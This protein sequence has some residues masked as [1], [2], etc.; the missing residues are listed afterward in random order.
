MDVSDADDVRTV[1]FDRPDVMNAFTPETAV[2]LATVLDEANPSDHDAVVLTGEGTAFSAGG[3]IQSMAERDWTPR[4]AYERVEETFGRLAET[5]LS[6]PV[7]I[8]AK[9][10]GDA[11]GA[12]LAVVAAAD[13]AYATEEV[14]L[15]AAFAKVGLVPDTAATFLLPRL[16]GLRRAKELIFTADTYSATEMA[17]M[18][19]L[20]EAVPADEL[21]ETVDDLLATLAKRPTKTLG[22]AK[23]ALH[24]NLGAWEEA[25]DYEMLIQ[26][27]AYA[28]PEHEEGV[29]AFLEGRRPEFE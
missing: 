23:Q 2:E 17:E 8:V 27:Q 15:G 1:T 28:T 10:N 19:F 22:L 11:V 26:S 16:V 9:V 20:N 29:A 21:D 12:G 13:F 6:T 7:P 3:D 5:M 14:R 18:D 25:L 4:E 24:G